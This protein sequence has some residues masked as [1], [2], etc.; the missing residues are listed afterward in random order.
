[1]NMTPEEIKEKREEIARML[2]ARKIQLKVYPFAKTLKITADDLKNV[3][4]HLVD[5]MVRRITP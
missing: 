2:C 4:Q 1:M 3:P 5:K